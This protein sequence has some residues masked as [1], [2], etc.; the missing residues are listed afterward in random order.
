MEV[1]RRVLVSEGETATLG[2]TVDSFPRTRD[3]VKWAREGFD[4]GKHYLTNIR[5]RM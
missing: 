2:C 5:I 3:T 4:L 1:T